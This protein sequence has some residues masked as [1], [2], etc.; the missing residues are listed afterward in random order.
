MLWLKHTQKK[1]KGFVREMCVYA[2]NELEVILNEIHF[3][4]MR[5]FSI[6]AT[7]IVHERERKKKEN[8]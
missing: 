6:S 7:R 8:L 1:N 5:K 4:E 3:H 2:I